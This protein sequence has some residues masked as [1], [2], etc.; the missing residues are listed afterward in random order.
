MSLSSRCADSDMANR[1]RAT[2]ATFTPLASQSD[3]KSPHHDERQTYI[4]SKNPNSLS[5][6]AQA[7][8]TPGSSNVE[9]ADESELKVAERE[10]KIDCTFCASLGQ[11]LQCCQALTLSHPCPHC[12]DLS[13]LFTRKTNEHKDEIATLHDKLQRLEEESPEQK[14][15]R[16][17]GEK[18]TKIDMLK[19]EVEQ[20]NK[21]DESLKAENKKLEKK[22]KMLEAD[23]KKLQPPA[24]FTVKEKKTK[25]KKK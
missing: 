22:L 5:P 10:T 6:D 2:A 19:R 9:V 11:P 21:E 7:D 16:L 3:A 17:C 8:E 23:I 24:E 15:T 20:I 25:G 14:F 13:Q 1:L 12:D 18:N 4:T